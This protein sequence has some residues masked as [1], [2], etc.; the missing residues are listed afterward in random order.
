LT[1]VQILW[2]VYT[3]IA[4]DKM[5]TETDDGQFHRLVI[6]ST[7]Q[8]S[9]TCKLS[10]KVRVDVFGNFFR[11]IKSNFG[12]EVVFKTNGITIFTSDLENENVRIIG[13][14]N[15]VR[16]QEKYYTMEMSLRKV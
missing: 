16:V 7:T 15:P 10:I 4:N 9:E 11:F 6:N 12:E 1:G 5:L 2:G 8:R 3:D 14:S 13:Y